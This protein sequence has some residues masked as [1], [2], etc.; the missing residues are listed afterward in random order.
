MIYW[1]M[2]ICLELTMIL[3]HIYCS[4]Y[5]SFTLLYIVGELVLISGLCIV[6]NVKGAVSAVYDWD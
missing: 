1:S 3:V 6:F 4:N 2:S 5:Y